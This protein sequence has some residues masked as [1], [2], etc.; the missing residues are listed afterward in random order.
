MDDN[1]KTLTELSSALNQLSKNMKYMMIAQK[2]RMKHLP[3][4]VDGLI[5]NAKVINDY[6]VHRDNLKNGK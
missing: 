5:A 1:Q 3:E 4:M 6:H 2:I